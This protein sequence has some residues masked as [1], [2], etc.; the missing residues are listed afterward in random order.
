[1][2]VLQHEPSQILGFDV[3]KDTVT[4]YDS[5]SG[6]L[7]ELANQRRALKAFIARLDPD[8]LAICEPTG[9]H[10]ALLIGE[11]TAQGKACHRAD[12]LKVKAFIRSYGTLA[13][14]DALDAKALASYG[15]ERWQ[16]LALF[17]P[18]SAEQKRLAALVGRRQDLIALKVAEQNRCKAPADKV[19]KTSCR[20]I[21]AAVKRQIAAIEAEI[22]ALLQGSQRLARA[23]T[24]MQSLA[25]VGPKTAIGL[26]ALMPELGTLSRRQAASLAGLAP[27]PNDSGRFKGYRSMRGGRPAIRSVLFMAALSASRAKGPL[28]HFYQRLIDNGKKPIV[29]ISALMRKIIVILNAKLR[30]DIA[31]QS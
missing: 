29:A 10:E 18:A 7:H 9:G 2:P 22:E 16:Q 28:G 24:V 26:A 5:R 23:I 25:G 21:L 3:S 15:H 8:C 13:K 4:V 17:T 1:M 11:L 12:T 31:K 14:T 30:D 20:A 6:Q 19:V 27:H